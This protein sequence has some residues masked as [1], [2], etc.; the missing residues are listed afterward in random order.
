MAAPNK[1]FID[2]T[3]EK[4]KSFLSNECISN[5]LKYKSIES[6]LACHVGTINSS[7]FANPL[8]LAVSLAQPLLISSDQKYPFSAVFAQRIL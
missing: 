7:V 2:K 8:V 6:K 5:Y 1:H 4:L 3:M